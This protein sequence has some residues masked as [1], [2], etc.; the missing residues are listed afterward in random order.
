MTPEAEG[1]TAAEQFRRNH[2]LG[3]QPLGDLVAVIEQATGVDVAVLDAG[4]DEHGLTMQDPAR[5]YTVIAVARTEHPM[6]QR[7]SM[8]HELAHVIF[9]DWQLNDTRNWDARSP[10][11][12][13]ADAFARHLLI[14]VAAVREQV[15]DLPTVDQDTLSSLAQR[16]LVSPRS[17]RSP[18]ATP[19]ISMRQPTNS[20]WASPLPSLLSDTDGSTTTVPCRR[21]RIVPERLRD[22]SPASSAA[23]RKALS[24]PR[25]SLH[26]EALTW[27]R[28][29]TS[30]PTQASTHPSYRSRGPTAL[31]C[32]RLIL[33]SATFRRRGNTARHRMN[34]RPIIDAGPALNLLSINQERLLV[35]LSDQSACPK[36]S[37]RRCSARHALTETFSRR[38]EHVV[39]AHPEVG[40][41]PLRRRDP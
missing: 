27:P 15:G 38:A 3:L 33:T 5:G 25:P 2:H 40:Q 19:A 26:S 22:C 28:S 29:N 41:R 13:R 20:G 10:D 9:E 14:P 1:R 18:S 24:P 21:S 36:L 8:A 30:S 39:E 11:E 4:P 34:A 32:L 12:V 23:T 35:E 37:R 16:F 31:P 17:S 7:S 6:R